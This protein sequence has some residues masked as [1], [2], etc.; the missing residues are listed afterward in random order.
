MV[1]VEAK[2]PLTKADLKR[3][4]HEIPKIAVF[5]G[6]R[7]KKDEYYAN[8]P[9]FHFRLRETQSGTVMTLKRKHREKG[10][11]VNR[12][13]EFTIRSKE[14]FRK[15]LQQNGFKKMVCKE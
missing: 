9:S 2:V 4:Q 7:V 1:E 11:E 6:E 14:G 8:G 3:L 12:E 15:F 13:I 5:Q 10:T